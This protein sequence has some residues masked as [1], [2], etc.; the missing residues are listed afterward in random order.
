[1]DLTDL[2]SVVPN[3]AFYLVVYLF[4]WYFKH[5]IAIIVA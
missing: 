4:Y 1:M 2:T 5:R 3:Y